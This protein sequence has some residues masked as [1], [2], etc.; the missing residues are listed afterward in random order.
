MNLERQEQFLSVHNSEPD[1]HRNDNART[2][3]IADAYI[4]PRTSVSAMAQLYLLWAALSLILRSIEIRQL[5]FPATFSKTP[6]HLRHELITDI[7]RYRSNRLMVQEVKALLKESDKRASYPLI[8]TTKVQHLDLP[9]SIGSTLTLEK[10][11]GSLGSKPR[12]SLPFSTHL[13]LDRSGR[14]ASWSGLLDFTV[15]VTSL[16]YLSLA[17]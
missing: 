7:A 9:K 2:H 15:H 16:L 13:R 4:L 8:K 10:V 3:R 6:T 17:Y 11:P 5:H 14:G 12:I 1:E